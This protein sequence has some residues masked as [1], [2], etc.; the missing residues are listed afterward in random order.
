MSKLRVTRPKRLH[1]LYHFGR[2][3]LEEAL[4]TKWFCA[5]EKRSWKDVA[6]SAVLPILSDCHIAGKIRH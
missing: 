5:D 3:I 4:S 1:P 2:H 6:A